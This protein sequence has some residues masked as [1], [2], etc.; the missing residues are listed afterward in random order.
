MIEAACA[1]LPGAAA[2]VYLE[3]KVLVSEVDGDGKAHFSLGMKGT[4]QA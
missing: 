4:D 2:A 1:R 3:Y